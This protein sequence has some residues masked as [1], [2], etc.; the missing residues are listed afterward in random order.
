M[1]WL[2]LGCLSCAEKKKTFPSSKQFFFKSDSSLSCFVFSQVLASWAGS[3]KCTSCN[4]RSGNNR[5]RVCAQCQGTMEWDIQQPS[6]VIQSGTKKPYR[7]KGIVFTDNDAGFL[8]KEHEADCTDK[9]P[10]VDR[11]SNVAN[12]YT[13]ITPVMPF[14]LNPSGEKG[15]VTFLRSLGKR[16]LINTYCWDELKEGT[17]KSNEVRYS[18]DLV[19]DGCPTTEFYNNILFKY[20]ACYCCGEKDLNPDTLTNHFQDKH[21]NM[22]SYTFGKDFGCEFSWVLFR[23]GHLHVEMAILRV[24]FAI[25]TPII[26]ELLT[27]SLDYKGGSVAYILSGKDVH[28]SHEGNFCRVSTSPF[29]VLNFG[30]STFWLALD[31]FF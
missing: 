29:L 20:L 17:L 8:V 28:L 22:T 16:Y 25:L 14:L 24:Y 26:G 5:L 2:A 3:K 15:V 10:Q 1:F 9:Y 11:D 12:D 21:A 4:W 27:K 18:L 13:E 30:A 7:L 19:M 31:G 6:S 23:E